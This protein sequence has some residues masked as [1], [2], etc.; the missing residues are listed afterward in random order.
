[1][2]SRVYF[3]GAGGTVYYRDNADASAGTTGQIAFFGLDE[4][5]AHRSDYDTAIRIDTPLTADGEG[6]LYFGFDAVA[7]NPLHLSSGIVRIGADGVPAWTPVTTASGDSTVLH[8]MQN[9]A[10]ALSRDGT[11]LY[12]AVRDGL[13]AG[14]LL[15]LDSATLARR[16]S[17]RLKDP[18]TGNDAVLFDSGTASAMIGPDGD[19]YY[20]VF[21]SDN[22]NHDR[23]WLLHFDVSLAVVKTPGAFGWDDTP[24]LVPAWMVPS[25]AG[26]SAYLLMTKYNNYAE[27]GGDGMNRIAVL[28]PFASQTDSVTGVTVMQEVLTILGPTPDG[29]APGVKE[30]C[31]NSAAVDPASSSVIVTS[32]DGHVYRWDLT[33]NR[34][35]ESL[36]LTAGVPE[37]YTPTVIGPDGAI[38]AINNST[39]FSVGN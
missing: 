35:S 17:V 3:A 16:A 9:C 25:Y 2:E 24:S 14:Y 12:V 13:S 6:N 29:G 30:W 39:L 8:V 18:F 33:G 15:A 22:E 38:Y 19:V 10:P 28:D 20:G 37:P 36:M 11:T 26:T 23:G 34:F 4:Y 27:T 1:V 7:D 5:R 21:E 31:I 32:E